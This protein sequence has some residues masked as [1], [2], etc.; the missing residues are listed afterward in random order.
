M[1]VQKKE[2]KVGTH[3]I[4]YEFNDSMPWTDSDELLEKTHIALVERAAGIRDMM[5]DSLNV[6]G[7]IN[8]DIQEVRTFLMLVKDIFK[9]AR[10]EAD[11]YVESLMQMEDYSKDTLDE[12]VQITVKAL[13]EYHKKLLLL[14]QVVIKK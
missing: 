14:I 8:T 11:F 7:H 10:D 12:K 3:T 2:F 13:E 5:Y 9:E 1:A 4:S 6:Y